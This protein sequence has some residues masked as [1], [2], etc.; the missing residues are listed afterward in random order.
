MRTS[1]T[2][3]GAQPRAEGVVLR[4]EVVLTTGQVVVR[5]EGRVIGFKANALQGASGLVLRFTRLDS[6]SKILVDRAAALRE[7][8]R[9][10]PAP[11]SSPPI[12]RS[13]P[14][15]LPSV[16]PSSDALAGPASEPP[17]RGSVRPVAPTFFPPPLP[18]PSPPD[19]RTGSVSQPPSRGSVRPASPTAS[20]PP[21]RSP[22][23][24]EVRAGSD[25]QSPP[26]DGSVRPVAPTLVPAPPI[27]VGAPVRAAP[28][29]LTDDLD[30]DA[31]LGRLRDRARSLNPASLSDILASRQAR[32]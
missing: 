8:R 17:S 7:S 25:N 12:Q 1:V 19:L 24:P 16:R 3:V 26:P 13:L 9:P 21:L 15:P 2:L 20:S 22:A 10:A 14:P 23:L 31:L 18:T 27:P 30:R 29:V 11:Q 32:R 4:F 28:V 6:R 5:G